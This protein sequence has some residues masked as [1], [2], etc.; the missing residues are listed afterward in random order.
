[1]S[2]INITFEDLKK[3]N[4]EV[5]V[6][7]FMGELDE[8]NIDHEALKIYQVID[9]MSIPNL[10]LDFSAL[11]YMNSKSI[12]YVTDWFSKTKTKNGKI[13]ICNPKTNIL[14]IL[15]VVGLANIMPIHKDRAV[16]EKEFFGDNDTPVTPSV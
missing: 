13:V 15:T 1:M 12:G 6:I 11:D 9:E 8:T 7:K 16:A 2:N 3:G 5:K 10:I 14:D 4:T